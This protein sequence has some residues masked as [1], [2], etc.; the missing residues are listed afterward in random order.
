[1]RNPFKEIGGD[2][3]KR[4]MKWD[5]AV[6]DWLGGYPYDSAAPAEIKEF[7]EGFGFR[8]EQTAKTKDKPG[9]LGMGN[10]E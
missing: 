5:T 7:V 1:L 2:N 8:L 4:G 10:A 9:L 3:L 6:I